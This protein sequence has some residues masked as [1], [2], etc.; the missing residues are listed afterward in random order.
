MEFHVGV[1]YK[2]CLAEYKILPQQLNI[3]F[4]R[5]TNYDG[6]LE[7]K[8][9]DTLVMIKGIRRWVGSFDHQEFLNE[10]GGIID[11]KMK[12]DDY[13]NYKESSFINPSAYDTI[14]YPSQKQDPDK[15]TS[16]LDT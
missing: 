12:S 5:L 6:D 14:L 16:G 9:P 1:L 3:Y 8:P 15:L 2:G 11:E 4:A 7:S 10:I 13:I